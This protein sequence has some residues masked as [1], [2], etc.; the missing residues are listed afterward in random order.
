[1]KKINLLLACFAICVCAF[2][3]APQK[4]NYQGIARGSSG[5]VFSNQTLG[6]KISVLQGSATGTAVYVETQAVTSD[7][8]G[9]FSLEVGTGTIVSGTFSA[10]TWGSNSFWLKTEM[11]TAGGSN[12][13][14]M[15][16]TQ[17]ISVPY[18]LYS[19]TTGDT[20]MWKKNGATLY[21]N[22]GAVEV[23]GAGGLNIKN[24][25]TLVLYDP[26]N[27]AYATFQFNGRLY[28]NYPLTVSGVIES[29]T[30]G[31][32]F[33]D[34]TIQTSAATAGGGNPAG[35]VI[36]FAGA[37]APAGYLACN[38]AAVSR[39]TYA[40]LF[41]AIGTAWGAGDGSTTFNLPDLRGRFMRGVDGTAGND[42]DKATRTASNT[43][44]NT[45]NTVGSLQADQLA[46]HSHLMPSYASAGGGNVNVLNFT[47]VNTTTYPTS[48]T[49]GSETRPKN[50]DV[51]FIIK[52]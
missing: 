17:M 5:K 36:A 18:S 23:G 31:V 35:T 47:A 1:M 4:F 51:N 9:I 39:T 45:G 46:S 30:G 52:F 48:A 8:K 28:E 21:Y 27:T 12:Y 7:S 2:A 19:E 26:T 37:T 16:T 44:G 33:P 38:G 32:K 15:G 20:S 10:I 49:G 11:D 29:T 50:V 13:Q 24:G 34:G 6:F 3:Q 43:G 14:T 42:P 41:T 25:K 22:S 40:A